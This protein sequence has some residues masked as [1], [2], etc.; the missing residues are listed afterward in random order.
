MENMLFSPVGTE[1]KYKV[2]T[3]YPFKASL[4][5]EG[6]ALCQALRVYFFSNLPNSQY[7]RSH[8]L[9]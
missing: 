4:S 6:A 1:N 8:S 5:L 7:L 2:T 9:F 3:S